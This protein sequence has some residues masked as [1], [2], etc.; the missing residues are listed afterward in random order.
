M[1]RQPF[2]GMPT[3]Q[4][5]LRHADVNAGVWLKRTLQMTLPQPVDHLFVA[6]LCAYLL[7]ALLGCGPWVSALVAI[8][9]GFSSLN[10]LYTGAGHAAKVMSIAILPGILA[11]ILVAYRRNLW[12]GAG[13]A[14]AFTAANLAANHLQMTY[15]LAFLAGAVGIAETVRLVRSGAARQALVT[16]GVLLA[17]A[18]VAVLPNAALIGPT[19]DYTPHTTRGDILL[20]ADSGAEARDAGLDKDYILQY[21]M[22]EGE[23]WSILVPDIKGETT[24]SIGVNSLQRRRFLFRGHPRRVVHGQPYPGALAP[25]AH[26]GG[27]VAR[28]RAVLARRLVAHGFLLGVR[29]R[30]REVPRH[31]D[32]ADPH[33]VHAAHWG[34][35]VAQ[36]CP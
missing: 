12:L 4:L 33:P 31:Q 25:L 28:H 18:L 36:G 3:I 7:A 16:G 32:D 20:S 17:A 23:W 15:Y 30:V 21:S 26:A 1:D 22:G 5:G 8:G 10:I 35:A 34:G 27:G 11:G 9:F 13:L 29:P 14:C 6:L 19:L 2:G 24:R